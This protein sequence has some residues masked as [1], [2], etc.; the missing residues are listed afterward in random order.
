MATNYQ[1]FTHGKTFTQCNFGKN[2][3]KSIETDQKY[4]IELVD[5][6]LFLCATCTFVGINACD[7]KITSVMKNNKDLDEDEF[8]ISY[9][10]SNYDSIYYTSFAYREKCIVYSL[11]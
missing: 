5:S 10:Y 2:V 11:A 4:V 6:G 8:Y 3:Y 1:V 9:D 7:M